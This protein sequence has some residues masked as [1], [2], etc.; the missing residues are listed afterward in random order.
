ME[1]FIPDCMKWLLAAALACA[2]PVAFGQA[3]VDEKCMAQWHDAV[4][5]EN[6]GTVCK[7]GD[8]ASMAKF[9][10]AEDAAL[11]CAVAKLAPDAA[12]G[13]A[14]QRSKDQGRDGQADGLRAL[15]GAGEGVL[16]A[17]LDATD[18]ALKDGRI[19]MRRGGACR[20]VSRVA[21]RLSWEAFRSRPWLPRTNRP[22]P[23]RT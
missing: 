10:A 6:V 4:A 14:R 17:A 3:Q 18:A 2:A 9:K 5:T 19:A 13:G 21:T 12:G 7:L 1:R 11:N 8:P 16:P 22:H 15:S 20:P 23:P